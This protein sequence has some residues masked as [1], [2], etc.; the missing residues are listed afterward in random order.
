MPEALE[1]HLG[2]Q[3]RKE[4]RAPDDFVAP[5]LF[6]ASMA[7]RMMTGHCVAVDGGVVVSG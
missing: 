7:S 3:C 5:T 2:R 6:L 1:A 4:H